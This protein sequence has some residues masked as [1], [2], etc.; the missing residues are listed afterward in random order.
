MNGSLVTIITPSYNS[1]NHIKTTIESVKSQTYQNWKMII[2]DDCSKDGSVKF[3]QDLVKDEARITLVVLVSNIGAAMARNK[4]LEMATG[5]FVAFLDADDMWA[6][7]KLEIQ[8]NFMLK[9][10]CAF[11]YTAYNVCDDSGQNIYGEIPVPSSLTYHQY[12][13]NTIIGCLTVMVDIKKLGRIQMP[14]L[15]S[16]HDMALWCDILKTIDKAQGI[17]IPLA[18]YRLV[19]SSNTA[20]KWKA[21]KDVWT[22][23]RTHLH[24]NIFVS[25]FYFVQYAFNAVKKRF[26]K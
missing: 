25:A 13:A 16:S 9:T 6:P 3:I 4:A 12:L 21:S 14:A 19:E 8:V 7:N 15:R 20:N 1:R 10:Q 22:V 23:Y 24:L 11:S 5:H 18:T 17:N 26:Y 2:V